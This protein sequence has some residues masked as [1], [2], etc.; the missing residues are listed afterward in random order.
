M[1]QVLQQSKKI[2]A[3]ADELLKETDLINILSEF[4]KVEITGS[5][6]ADLMWEADIDMHVFGKFTRKDILK[7]MEKL[8][9]ETKMTGYMF[10]DWVTYSNPNWPKGYYLGIK[11]LF[12]NYKKQWKIDIWFIGKEREESAKNMNLVSNLSDEEKIKILEC[13]KYKIDNKYS[14]PSTE[15]YKAILKDGITSVEEF[16]KYIIKNELK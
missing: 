14:F 1:N 10:F 13:K 5:Y 4:G 15:I 6:K 7:I 12:K 8:M 9:Q 16:K 3:D 11:Q 2:K